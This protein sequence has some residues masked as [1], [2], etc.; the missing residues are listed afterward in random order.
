MTRSDKWKT[1]D[2]V[3]RYREWS[4][5]TREA[6]GLS[7]MQKVP[8]E[9][10]WGIMVFAHCGIPPSYSKK[11]RA[12]MEGKFCE[13]K[14]DADNILKGVCDTLFENDEKLSAMTCY[15]YWAYDDEQPRIDI[16]LLPKHQPEEKD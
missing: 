2:I 4:D 5:K 12:S 6:A 7:P 13:T 8:A 3:V 10:Y 11:K 1:R 14:P 15:K 16:F 9:G